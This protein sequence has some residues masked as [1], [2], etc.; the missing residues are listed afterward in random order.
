MRLSA[1]LGAA[2]VALSASGALADEMTVSMHHLTAE[3]V[4]EAVGTVTITGGGNGAVFKADLKG[5]E[6]GQHGFHVHANG[7]CEPAKDKDGN[8]VPG[9]AAGGHWDPENTSRH[10]GPEGS[11]HLGDLPALEVAQDGTAT[12]EVT[13]PR[14]DDVSRLSGHALMIHAGGDNYSDE[15]K[16]L[17]GGGAR[18]VC[19]VID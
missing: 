2:A 6:P 1:L 12:G 11:G 19:G 14:I 7:S 8:M 15:P 16:P 5:L 3:G 17:G 10:A 13:A 9:L 4:G 18:M